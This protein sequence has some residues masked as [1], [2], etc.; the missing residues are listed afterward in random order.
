MSVGFVNGKIVLIH[1]NL[2]WLQPVDQPGDVSED[3][4]S[5]DREVERVSRQLLGLHGASYTDLELVEFWSQA[6]PL[7]LLL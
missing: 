6:L 2:G 4:A 3:V 7:S 5:G 1:R